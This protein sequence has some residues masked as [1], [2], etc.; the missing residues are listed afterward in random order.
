[1]KNLDELLSDQE[2]EQ[3]KVK[4]INTDLLE[5]VYITRSTYDKAFAYAKLVCKVSKNPGTEIVGYLITPKEARDRIARDAYLVKGQLAGPGEIKIN[6]EDVIKA[7]REIDAKG[8]RVLGWWHSHGDLETFHSAIDKDNQMTIL[9]AIA[10]FNYITERE[11]EIIDRNLKV[12]IEHGRLILFDKNNR[13]VRYE[14]E[15]EDASKIAIARMRLIEERRIGFAYSLVVHGSEERKYGIP[16]S[17]FNIG[18]FLGNMTGFNSQ[19]ALPQQ[20]VLPLITPESRERKPYAE[21]ATRRYCHGCKDSR[22]TSGRA[23]ILLYEGDKIEID[24]DR[25]RKEITEKVTFRT[26]EWTPGTYFRGKGK[27]GKK[28]PYPSYY[29]SYFKQEFDEK[30]DHEEVSSAITPANLAIPKN[31]I[32]GNHKN[33]NK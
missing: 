20:P 9:N 12:C 32:N 31:K 15:T 3:D 1:M 14:I 27:K 8:Y 22:D 19:P 5:E 10:P 24:E 21:I 25:L 11:E 6:P 26:Y 33:G 13:G 18:R 28:F 23:D 30:F 29:G 16:T 4:Q 17:H 7:G 2:P